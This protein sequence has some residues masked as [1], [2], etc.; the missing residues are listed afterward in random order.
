MTEANGGN[1]A[2]GD[3]AGGR[4]GAPPNEVPLS[5]PPIA[6]TAPDPG[7]PPTAAAAPPPPP[8]A[9]LPPPPGPGFTQ[10]PGAPV[11]WAAPS[12]SPTGLEVPGA[13]GL[14]FGSTLARFL[15]WWIDLIAIAIA[16]GLIIWAIE[17]AAPSS[18]STSELVSVVIFMGVAFLYFVGLWTSSGRATLGMRAMKLQVGNAFDG[19]TLTIEQAIRRWVG[20]GLP[21][22]ALSL[23][24]A[25]SSATGG[26]LFLW[27]LALLISTA[28]SSTR[29]GLHDRFANS[30]VVQPIG[31]S[32]PA[33]ACLV[34]LVL[35]LIVPVLMIIG[36]IFLGAQVSSILSGVGTSVYP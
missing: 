22:Q 31:A 30:A 18:P 1:G 32:T 5:P 21:F 10:P 34:V 9:A 23:V 14:R 16:A 12:A 2:A 33:T 36:L 3:N 6:A 17:V 15:A 35:L 27:Y 28:I 26:L 7:A 11:A 19:R 8:G 20:L 13:P 4:A 25:V 24:P 29:Q